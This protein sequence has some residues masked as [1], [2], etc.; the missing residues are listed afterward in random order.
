MLLKSLEVPEEL[1]Q[2]SNT[3]S[4]ILYSQILF[5]LK[6]ITLSTKNFENKLATS[7][8]KTEL[9]NASY[10]VYIYIYIYTYIYMIYMII[11]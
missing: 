1:Q 7:I 6:R 8:G 3:T 4:K 9:T 10:G 2:W 11:K 5:Q